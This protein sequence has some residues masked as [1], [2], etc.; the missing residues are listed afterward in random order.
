[1][2]GESVDLLVNT[3]A[4]NSFAPHRLVQALQLPIAYCKRTQVSILDGSQLTGSLVF[5][6]PVW[7]N[8]ICCI[9]VHYL[10]V[11]MQLPFISGMDL[12][13]MYRLR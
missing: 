13:G 6:V 12:L 3:S 4:S 1:M 2:Y 10:V 9:K 7:L 11:D 8:T 5:K